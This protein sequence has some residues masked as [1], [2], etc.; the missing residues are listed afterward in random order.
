VSTDLSRDHRVNYRA[1]AAFSQRYRPLTPVLRLEARPSSTER[2]FE[3]S[4][5]YNGRGLHIDPRT[6]VRITLTGRRPAI[7]PNGQRL[8]D[9]RL[10]PER[11][12][13]EKRVAV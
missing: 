9:L 6:P 11:L 4:V 12:P 13:V 7:R 5:T 2:T 8:G 3:S 1:L 10:E